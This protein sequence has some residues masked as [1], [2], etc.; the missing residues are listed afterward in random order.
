MGGRGVRL[1]AVRHVVLLTAQKMPKKPTRLQCSQQRT[2]HLPC[3]DCSHLSDSSHHC[4]AWLY[5]HL[6][7]WLLF[8]RPQVEMFPCISLSRLCVYQ[9]WVMTCGRLACCN[10]KLLWTSST[11]KARVWPLRIFLLIKSARMYAQVCFGIYLF[12][13]FKKR[14]SKHPYQYFV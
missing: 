7:P 8:H 12:K 9:M 11:V 14:M 3:F 13:L 10:V 6:C 4:V 1:R 5:H 2:H